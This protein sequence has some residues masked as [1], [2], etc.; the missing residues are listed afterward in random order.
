LHTRFQ[1]RQVQKVSPVD[2]EVFDLLLIQDSLDAGLL[3]I[4][5]DG[6]LGDRDDGVS[7]AH[8]E[9][10]IDTR[11][12][13]DFHHHALFGG[14]KSRGFGANGIVPGHERA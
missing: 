2:R 3:G 13:A 12:D 8:L 7:R 6:L 5:C 11:D 9:T 14:L 4:D 10:E 1:L